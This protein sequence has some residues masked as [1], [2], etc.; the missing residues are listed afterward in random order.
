MYF[1]WSKTSLVFTLK[2]T[3]AHILWSETRNCYSLF[4]TFNGK[5][6]YCAQFSY[7]KISAELA[8]KSW[9]DFATL[10][11][12]TVLRRFSQSSAALRVEYTVKWVI[13]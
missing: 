12:Q 5:V 3:F 4:H 8:E 6:L 11:G 10:T 1:L 13:V 2:M 9:E 7:D